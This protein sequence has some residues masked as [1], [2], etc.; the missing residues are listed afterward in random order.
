MDHAVSLA[1]AALVLIGFIASGS[2]RLRSDGVAYAVLNGAGSL[3]LAATMLRPLNAGGLAL[4]LVW[5]AY[6]VRL[7]VRALRRR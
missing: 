1:G 5:A 3:L 2:G 4:E 6:S 7:L